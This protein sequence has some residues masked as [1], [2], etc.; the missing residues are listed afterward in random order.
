MWHMRNPFHNCARYGVGVS[1]KT[2]VRSGK[3]PKRIGNPN[4]GW[5]YAVVKYKRLRLPVISYQGKCFE[6]YFGWR[7]GGDF[8]IA[9]RTP[10]RKK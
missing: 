8:G 7:T 10:N 4:G 2:F 6:C 1:D 5:N 3:Y 9:M